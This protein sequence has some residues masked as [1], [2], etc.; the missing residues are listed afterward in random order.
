MVKAAA[1]SAS[2]KSKSKSQD[3]KLLIGCD[4]IAKSKPLRGGTDTGLLVYLFLNAG[5]VD[6]FSLSQ[7]RAIA[8]I[9]IPVSL[10]Q[11]KLGD[12]SENMTIM[13][14]LGEATRVTIQV[15]KPPKTP[16]RV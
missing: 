16:S 9:K 2:W 8:Q 6:S 15:A 14:F 1:A 13:T 11:E 12:M 3:S 10:R 7:S 5:R 4:V